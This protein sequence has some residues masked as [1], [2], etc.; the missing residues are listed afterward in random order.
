MFV[1]HVDTIKKQHVQVNVKIERTAES[2][3]ECDSTGMSCD[4]G[5]T[6]FFGNVRGACMPANLYVESHLR[7]LLE[8]QDNENQQVTCHA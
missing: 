3:D 6:G 1:I 4:F 2:L 8:Q 7:E 5:V